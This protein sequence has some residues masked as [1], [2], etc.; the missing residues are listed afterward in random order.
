MPVMRGEDAVKIIQ[1]EFGKDRI[2]IVT[3]TASA[4]NQRRDFYLNIGCHEFISKPFK[5]EEIFNCLDQL[6][7]VEY[8]YDDEVLRKESPSIEELD[9]SQVSIPEDLYEKIKESA[10]QYNIT[11]LEKA[12]KELK[13]RAGTSKQLLEHLELLAKKNEMEAIIKALESVPKTKD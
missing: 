11:M 10:E 13:E 1:E 2:K 7:G 6:L 8:I 5:A 9:P 3:I 4:L 12:L